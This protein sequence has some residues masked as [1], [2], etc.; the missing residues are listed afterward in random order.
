MNDLIEKA[1]VFATA[2]HFAIGQKRKYSNDDYI[3]HPTAVANHVMS[4]PHTPEMVAAAF[5]HDVW[6]DTDVPLDVIRAEFG[7]TVA[8][9]VELLSDPPKE[10]QPGMNREARKALDIE[11]LRNAPGDVQTIK[12]ADFIDNTGSIA[13][14]DPKFAPVYL[15]EKQ[16]F[17]EAMDK[18]DPTLRA[19]AMA[20]ATGPASLEQGENNE[21]FS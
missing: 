6:E 3:I 17:L 12:Y 21:D 10:S 18:G 11:R 15:R 1:R 9:Y 8:T 20:I 14:R 7:D 19:K 5:L 2:A 13:E 4:V 16:K